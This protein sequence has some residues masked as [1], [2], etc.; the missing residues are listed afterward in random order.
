MEANYA[1]LSQDL[2]MRD[3]IIRRVFFDIPD[4]L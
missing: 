2:K 4:L 3:E 1:F